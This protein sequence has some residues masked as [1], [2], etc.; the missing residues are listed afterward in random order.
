M[1]KLIF[2]TFALLAVASSESK[3]AAQAKGD[4]TQTCWRLAAGPFK[5]IVLQGSGRFVADLGVNAFGHVQDPDKCKCLHYHGTLFG[6]DEPNSSCGWGCVIEVPC[7]PTSASEAANDMRDVIDYIYYEVDADLGDKLYD[8]FQMMEDAAADGCYTVVD[9]L[10][11]ALSDELDSYFRQFGYATLWDPFV[12][13]LT[14]YVNTRLNALAPA[15]FFPN[16]VAGA[17]QI[18]SRIGS[19]SRG[20]LIDA[21]PRV[22]LRLGEMLT[23]QSLVQAGVVGNYF[24]QYKWKGADEGE[25]PSA[26]AIAVFNNYVTLVAYANTSLRLSALF[27]NS[28]G[29]IYRDVL[30]VNWSDR[31][32]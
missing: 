18:L 11:G 16:T 9:A 20:R 14:E 4:K 31:A 17:I 22:T 5:G 29:Q 19:G 25:I 30:M 1:K 15:P 3:V 8:I 28:S 23:L 21:G 7:S 12:Q 6:F 26:A 32:L 24:W 13:D 10:A 27:R 2:I